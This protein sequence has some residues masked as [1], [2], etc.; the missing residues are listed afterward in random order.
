VT[1]VCIV[2]SIS[3]LHSTH[4]SQVIPFAVCSFTY[5]NRYVLRVTTIL[6]NI[7]L[8]HILYGW[9]NTYSRM[10]DDQNILPVYKLL[11]RQ[12]PGHWI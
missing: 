12:L 4:Q 2:G 6:P 3:H 10:F 5:S 7:H 1:G 8:L 11:D 9:D